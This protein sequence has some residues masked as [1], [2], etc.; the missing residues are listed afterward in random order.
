MG[1]S[2]T[3][4]L[5]SSTES[6]STDAAVVLNE[7]SNDLKTP[8]STDNPRPTPTSSLPP[9]LPPPP[10]PPKV[11]PFA[12]LTAEDVR[13]VT[14]HGECVQQQYIYAMSSMKGLR[15]RMEDAHIILTSIPVYE[16]ESLAD[17]SLF[18]V[19]DGHGGDF[20]SRFLEKMLTETLSK[21]IELIEYAKLPDTGRSSRSDVNGIQ[22]LKKAIIKAFSEIDYSL[23]PQQRQKNRT[24]I[25]G[26]QNIEG[27]D[28]NVT[29]FLSNYERSGSTA[30]VVVLTPSHIVCANV[31]DSRAILRRAS[32]AVPLSFDHK[33][34]NIPERLRIERAGGLIKGK[35][36]DGDLAV[37]RAFG[38]FVHKNNTTLNSTKQKVTCRPDVTICRRNKKNDQFLVLACDGIWDVISNDECSNLVN[39]GITLATRF[40]R[41]LGTI[42]EE[43]IDESFIE[44]RS[45]DNMT[46][47]IIGFRT[48]LQLSGKNSS[49]SC[50]STLDDMLSIG[51]VSKRPIIRKD[52][53]KNK[54]KIVTTHSTTS[55]SSTTT[56]TFSWMKA[57]LTNP[58]S[59]ESKRILDC[60]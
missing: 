50:Y 47:M 51:G 9:P 52:R 45:R 21:R 43:V 30:I 35:R 46:V 56:S 7:V 39:D 10:P 40:P 34:S 48:G 12:N 36:I 16:H 29:S 57:A 25:E 2:Q 32:A 55:P 59:D 4:T 13:K 24:L 27:D 17:H 11:D 54:Q 20:T 1:N 42:C 26:M 60:V 6:V 22:L 33:P 38:D 28:N 53:N 19:F 44:R 18:C 41:D 58:F 15:P 8:S 3:M 23:L 14:E 37:S 31:G 5:D 49:S